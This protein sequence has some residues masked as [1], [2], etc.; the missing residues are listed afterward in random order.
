MAEASNL[1]LVRYRV[2]GM[3]CPSCAAKIEAA[4]RKLGIHDVKV[5]I[6]S[7]LMSLR[8]DQ[9]ERLDELE[10]AVSQLG[11][12]LHRLSTEDAVPSQLR[13]SYKRALWLVISLN[14][15]YGLVE[16]VGGFLADSQALQ[17]DALDFVGDGLITFF[18]LLVLG[19]SLDWRARAA[20]LQGVFLGLLGLGVFGS[21][22]YR[23]WAQQDPEP[24]MMGALGLVALV[25]NVAAAVVLVP[26]R[27]GDANVKAI[28]HFTRNDAIG[29]L[30]VVLAAGLVAWLH[31]PWPDLVVALVISGLFLQ[32]SWTII[33]DARADLNESR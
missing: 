15:G 11:Y 17:A 31:N 16:M 13:P 12:E 22:L 6:A 18:G 33:G 26:H 3:D 2:T 4:V 10:A 1:L 21:T 25:V 19:W 28:W 27:H 8:L 9:D 30:A 20:F 14:L 29:N 5:S 24:E 7:Q 32:S 23:I